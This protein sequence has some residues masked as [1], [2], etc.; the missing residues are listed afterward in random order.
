MRWLVLSTTFFLILTACNYREEKNV[1]VFSSGPSYISVREEIFKPNCYRCHSGSS[2]EMGIDLSS[3][4]ELMKSE[5][6]VITPGEPLS[7]TLYL[8]VQSGRMPPGG[9][10]LSDG[11]IK[12]IADWIKNGA[13]EN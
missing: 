5:N 10:R 6:G 11:E 1:K 13:R 8:N 3:Y 12:I 2:A 7:S 9:P 4:S